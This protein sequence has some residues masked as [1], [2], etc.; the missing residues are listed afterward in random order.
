MDCSRHYPCGLIRLHFIL[1]LIELCIM[2]INL[3]GIP[4]S[5]GL[6]TGSFMVHLPSLLFLS[7]WVDQLTGDRGSSRNHGV[8]GNC[9]LGLTYSNRFRSWYPLLI[10]FS[11]SGLWPRSWLV[12]FNQNE[13][14]TTL[15]LANNRKFDRYNGTELVNAVFTES[16]IWKENTE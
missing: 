6:L 11:H 16:I 4:K 3:T 8:R 7:S 15:D 10:I 14:W 2:C 13:E 9:D 5:V 12:Y 1:L